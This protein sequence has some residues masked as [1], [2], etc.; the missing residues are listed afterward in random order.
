MTSMRH[1]GH[2]RKQRRIVRRNRHIV[3]ESLNPVDAVNKPDRSDAKPSIDKWS[4]ANAVFVCRIWFCGVTRPNAAAAIAVSR[5][6]IRQSVLGINS[7]LAARYWSRPKRNN[8][9]YCN[10][11]NKNEA[12]D[13]SH[14]RGVSAI[15]MRR[16]TPEAEISAA[17]SLPMKEI[18]PER[19]RSVTSVLRGSWVSI[20]RP[21]SHR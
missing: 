14:A 19:Q 9:E 13:M 12:I 10:D 6:R 1:P 15:L 8:N 18:L 3:N 21:N 7:H 17:R 16:I 20:Y 11:G 4:L 2:R 5:N